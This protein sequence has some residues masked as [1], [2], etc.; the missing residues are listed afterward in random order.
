MVRVPLLF[1]GLAVWEQNCGCQIGH[2]GS[3]DS[4]P[5]W[6]EIHKRTVEMNRPQ[7]WLYQL[8]SSPV[9]RKITTCQLPASK[10]VDNFNKLDYPETNQLYFFKTLFKMP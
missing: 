8:H 2:L 3:G 4:Q 1:L 10:K 6:V 7:N 9:H 5:Y